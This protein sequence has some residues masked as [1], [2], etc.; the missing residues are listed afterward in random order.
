MEADDTEYRGKR[1]GKQQ[2]T[3]VIQP[4]NMLI[5]VSSLV[6]LLPGW[7]LYARRTWKPRRIC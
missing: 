2:V 6:R 5:R 1:R 3:R 4:F 7:K